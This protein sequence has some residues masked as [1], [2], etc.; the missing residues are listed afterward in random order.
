MALV[1]MRWNGC[2]YVQSVPVRF[3]FLEQESY[4]FKTI[5]P[6]NLSEMHFCITRWGLK[7]PRPYIILLTNFFEQG[8]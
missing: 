3:Y 2:I 6:N 7:Q 8:L 4:L 1:K 5:D